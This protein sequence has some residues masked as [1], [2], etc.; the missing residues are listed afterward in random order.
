MSAYFKNSVQSFSGAASAAPTFS[1]SI[2]AQVPLSLQGNSTL[3]RTLKFPSSR[4]FLWDRTPTG[5]AE[6][7]EAKVGN[8]RS[9]LNHCYVG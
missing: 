5:C 2:V 8:L 7:V 9:L 3:S 6:V 4:K 1:E